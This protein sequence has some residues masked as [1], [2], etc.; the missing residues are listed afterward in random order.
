MKKTGTRAAAA[1]LLAAA[2]TTALLPPVSADEHKVIPAKA[3]MV[4]GVTVYG[5]LPAFHGAHG[6][7]NDEILEGSL[8]HALLHGEI[9]RQA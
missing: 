9:E 3:Q 7:R 8:R 1:L 4:T 5:K 6:R 2:L